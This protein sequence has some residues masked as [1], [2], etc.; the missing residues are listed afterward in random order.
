M[1]NNEWNPNLEL[2]IKDMAL[3]CYQRS[4]MHSYEADKCNR[5]EWWITRLVDLL[6]ALSIIFQI[7]TIFS[8]D[9]MTIWAIVTI[10]TNAFS[11][12]ITEWGHSSQYGSQESDHIKISADYELMYQNILVTTSPPFNKRRPGN[13]Y[14][15]YI[16]NTY[17][18]IKT[19][20]P[21]IPLKIQE[22]YENHILHGLTHYSDVIIDIE[23]PLGATRRSEENDSKSD[24]IDSDRS[25]TASENIMRYRLRHMESKRVITEIES[26]IEKKGLSAYSEYEMHRLFHNL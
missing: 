24:S 14:S 25:E 1:E 6:G 16:N 20:G 4:L 22:K 10:V 15:V 5:Y 23:H 2:Y 9:N 26:R 7:I 18:R 17:I 8:K 19:N 12:L 21:P 3:R 13:E 11:L